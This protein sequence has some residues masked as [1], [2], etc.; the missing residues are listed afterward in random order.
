MHNRTRNNPFKESKMKERIFDKV[1]T[2]LIV[3]VIITGFIYGLYCLLGL[4]GCII[5]CSVM[6]ALLC[7]VAEDI[8]RTSAEDKQL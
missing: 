5:Y 6:V 3:A 1:L 8:R 7:W 2:V 4:I